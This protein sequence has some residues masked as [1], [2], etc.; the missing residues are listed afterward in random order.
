MQGLYELQIKNAGGFKDE[1][2]LKAIDEG[3]LDDLL[4]D[5]PLD[6]S[7]KGHNQLNDWIFP[8]FAHNVIGH[9][10]ANGPWPTYDACVPFNSIC[11]TSRDTEPG[12]EESYGWYGGYQSALDAVGGSVAGRGFTAHI[13]EP[14]YIVVDPNGR[15]SVHMRTRWIYL[16]S[17]GNS[18]NIRGI[19]INGSQFTNQGTGNEDRYQVG[20]IRFKDPDTGVPVVLV[21]NINQVLIIEYTAIFVA[22]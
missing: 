7:L 1:D 12:P 6:R 2:F 22:L 9:G 17:Y 16:P 10:F 8:T 20:R 14:T 5:L 13:A 21:K 11:L 3:R 18:N 19:T 4:A 15:E